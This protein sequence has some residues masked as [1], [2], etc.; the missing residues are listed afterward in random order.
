[1]RKKGRRPGRLRGG[2]LTAVRRFVGLNTH[3]HRLQPLKMVH[4]RS[5]DRKAA[6]RDYGAQSCGVGAREDAPSHYCGRREFPM[7]ATN[8]VSFRRGRPFFCIFQFDSVLPQGSRS[9]VRWPILSSAASEERHQ[10]KMVQLP[11]NLFGCLFCRRAP[12][13][14]ECARGTTNYPKYK[15]LAK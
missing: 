2:S 3:T 8:S 7:M 14:P 15:Y 9:H 11:D 12:L 1:M 5:H 6:V 13:D 4:K 10:H